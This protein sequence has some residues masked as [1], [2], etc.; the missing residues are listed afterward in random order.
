MSD[1]ERSTKDSLPRKRSKVS[2]A[3]DACRRKKIRCDAEFSQTLQ[4]VTKICTNCVKNADTCTFSRVPLKRGPS[5]G[6]IR[7]LV[8]KMDDQSSGYP[9]THHTSV[10]KLEGRPRSKSVDASRPESIA[11]TIP[12]GSPPNSEQRSGS[13]SSVSSSSSVPTKPLLHRSTFSN[14]KSS[15]SPIILPPLLGPQPSKQPVKLSVPVQKVPSGNSVPLSPH[16]SAPL[17]SKDQKI[18]G[19]LWTVPYEMPNANSH[20]SDNSS[21]NSRNG[22]ASNSRRSS[23]DS[24][25]SISTAGSRSR[26]ASLKSTGNSDMAISDSDDDYYSSRSR[27]YSAMQSN[28]P[29]HSL[30]HNINLYYTKYHANFS[31]L[32]FSQQLIVRITHSLLNDPSTHTSMV[33]ELFNTALNNL[34]YYQHVPLSSSIA[35]LRNIMSIYPFNHNGI[36]VNDDLLIVFFSTLVLVN[37]TILINGDV[38]SLGIAMTASVFNDFKLLENFASLVR[39][40]NSSRLNPD[41][42]Q[43][44]LPRL[45]MCLYMID[46]TYSL[47]FGS[48]SNLPNNYGLFMQNIAI[49][50]P[51]EL[52][53]SPFYYNVQASVVINDLV[54]SRAESV[55]STILKPRYKESWSVKTSPTNPTNSMVPNFASLFVSLIKDKYELYDNLLEVM[56]FFETHPP[57]A[58]PNHG[59]DSIHETLYDFQL[60]IS[61][62]LKKLTQ[63]L[64]NFDNY[65]STIYSNNKSMS[66]AADLIGPF[67]NLSYGQSFKLIKACKLL[68]DPLMRY[69]TDS[70]LYTRSVKIMSD[71]SIAYNLLVS[72]VNNNLNAITN[73][74]NTL[75]NPNKFTSLSPSSSSTE[76]LNVSGL[77]QTSI[78]LI[79]SKIDH[80][81]LQF[82]NVPGPPTA[83]SSNSKAGNFG[84]WRR[85]VSETISSFILREDLDGW[86]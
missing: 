70:E 18:R 57:A 34:I 55:L 38:Y 28:L 49:L 60:K 73:A 71:L 47:S 11:P 41:D 23:V 33:V 50:M 61:R 36:L 40:P 8:D 15:S 83:D 31:V 27:A 45:Y 80:H 7:D 26:F 64:L 22:S 58:G 82:N 75:S 10:L 29:F 51:N 12:T 14:G 25:S 1:E 16:G 53:H 32:P 59:D 13:V 74:R 42:V 20:G 4:K 78:T 43:L 44:Y 24:I 79:L 72:N 63:S 46:N 77:G 39:D 67:F 30:E 6:Y 5:K 76:P 48:S 52:T 2:R 37:Y 54:S 3:C 69:A 86:F 56:R 85:E 62:L 68:V 17:E 19:P 35:L 21:T 81:N 66:S 84:A 65:I 9:N